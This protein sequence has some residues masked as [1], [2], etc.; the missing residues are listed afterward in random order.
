MLKLAPVFSDH[1]VLQRNKT[2][3]VFGVAPI[4]SEV[5]ASIIKDDKQIYFGYAFA[6]DKIDHILRADNDGY[7]EVKLPPMSAMTD[8]TLVVSAGDETVTY[9]DIAI[10]EVYLAGGQSNMEYEL[11]N[12]SGGPEFLSNGD[13][14]GV[15][16]YYTPKLAYIDDDYLKIHNDTSWQVFGKNN[17]AN[18]SA[19]GF[20]FA[21]ELSE[22]L[23]VTVG[24]IGCNW[25]GTVAYNWISRDALIANDQTRGYVEEYEGSEE[26]KKSIEEQY[27]DLKEYENY[28]QEWEEKAAKVYAENPMIAFDK[29]QELIGVCQY[30]GPIYEYNFFRPCGF[31]NTMLR[32][33]MP[34]T[35][36]GVIYYQGESD[37]VR[38]DQYGILLSTLIKQWRS[39]FR[40]KNLPFVIVGLPMHRY[41]HDADSKSWCTLRAKQKEVANSLENVAFADCID[42][43]EF[44]QIHPVEKRTVAHRLFL[45]IINMSFEKQDNDKISGPEIVELD[46]DKSGVIIR[47]SLGE[48][49]ICQ[50]PEDIKNYLSCLEFHPDEILAENWDKDNLYSSISNSCGFELQDIAGKWYP[51]DSVSICKNKIVVHSIRVDNPITIRYLWK[52]YFPVF[53]FNSNKLPLG[54]FEKII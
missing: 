47:L 19:V 51:A 12:C 31:Y 13:A 34:Y 9:T 16:F 22:R 54:A 10:G 44:H 23:G 6:T 39:D 24:V 37:E 46:K 14:P 7:F 25:G 3:A 49:Y 8:V 48:N 40:D 38:A 43:G 11:Q 4:G 53:V 28:S 15:R 50:N 36:A 5:K 45:Q 29:V 18:W 2:I 52:N 1:C 20:W 42:C 30:P 32:M 41:R 33:I 17:S 26:Y 21:K 27:N 35:L